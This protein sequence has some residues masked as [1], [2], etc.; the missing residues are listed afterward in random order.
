MA[1]PQA[2]EYYI[3]S[4]ANAANALDVSG[5]SQANGANVQTY[6]RNNSDAQMFKLSYR[7]DGTAQ[8]TSRLTGKSLDIPNG[9]LHSG[10]NVQ[11]WTDNDSRAQSWEIVDASGTVTV[12]GTSYPLY[13][14]RIASDTTLYM[15]ISGGATTPGANVQIYTG[16]DT[17]AQKWAFVPIPKFRDGG[18]YEI[19]ST[20]DVGMAVDVAG[21]S[22]VN[23][24]NVQLYT[25]N[26]TNAQK[27][28]IYDEGDGYSIRNIAS[29]KYVDVAG[30]AFENGTNVQSYEDND[31]R[32]QRWSVTAYGTRNVGGKT[33]QVV[34]FGA[35]NAHAYMMDATWAMAANNTNIWLYAT[36]NTAAQR[37]ALYPTSAL[38]P[39]LPT[40]HTIGLAERVGSDAQTQVG[41]KGTNGVV[42]KTYYPS[43]T[44]SD[45]WAADGPNH[46]EWRYRTR[47]MAS[48]TSSWGNWSSYT[49][50]ETA[51]VTQNGVRAW[52]TEGL[53]FS[54]D[55]AQHKSM[56]IEIEVRS[57]GSGGYS[58]LQGPVAG[59]VCTIGYI[60]TITLGNA[61]WSPDG[62]EIPVSCDY[63]KGT[64]KA[65]VM[66]VKSD[67]REIAARESVCTV[68]NGKIVVPQENLLGI[69][70]D[71]ASVV[72]TF[73]PGTDQVARFQ[74]KEAQTISASYT[75]GGEAPTTVDGEGLSLVATAPS[76]SRLWCI[77]DTLRECRLIS[78]DGENAT[79]EVLYPL[80]V[81]YELF[82]S[83]PDGAWHAQMPAKGKRVHAWNW[84]GG[85]FV[86]ELR[87]G[88]VLETDYSIKADYE[89]YLLNTR[90]RETVYA[91]RTF[92]GSYTAVGSD[93]PGRTD[94]SRE[95]AIA[96]QEAVHAVYR[97]PS[98][99]VRDVAVTGID[100]TV[101]RGITDY[102][103]SMVEEAV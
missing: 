52:V 68:E 95:S 21:G 10:A 6:S 40:P 19:R 88:E 82:M 45:S 27:F 70:Q 59:Q 97:S 71:G 39:T 25:A 56:Q 14:V 87:K 18:I 36:N 98:G 84:E 57:M 69:P 94:S 63:D 73:N 7:K 65:Y 78:D 47:K 101:Q 24:A 49:D 1:K 22:T 17:A 28:V 64:A 89:S 50:W 2:G 26:G 103:V 38:D 41:G 23:G 20:L 67:G 54:Y 5:G 31:S 90:P 75:A 86:L 93:V 79:F 61:T 43:W 34:A 35:G 46:Y 51:N 9:D 77:G 29:E 3:V 85:S 80:G 12:D 60:P 76:G 96:L 13:G 74:V 92:K 32:A 99:W 83:T 16:N 37:W 8:I 62:L 66:S 72:V 55:L 42:S 4:S 91:G 15:D 48:K 30:A 100:M 33:C 11:M 81:P 53:D 58:L 102:S 44:C